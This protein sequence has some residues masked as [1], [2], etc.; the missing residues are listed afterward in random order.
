MF[1][2]VV[3]VT[4]R[5]IRGKPWPGAGGLAG[6]GPFGGLDFDLA[7]EGE[8][9]LLNGFSLHIRCNKKIFILNIMCTGRC[10]IAIKVKL[11]PYCLT[12]WHLRPVGCVL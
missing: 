6:R 1:K 5:L 8:A 9:F 4:L 12:G 2:Q 10:F 7:G 11:L 3:N